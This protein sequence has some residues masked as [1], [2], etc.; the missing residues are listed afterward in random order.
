MLRSFADKETERAWQR[1]RVRK[2]DQG[3]QRAALRK[4][5]ILDAAETLDDLRVPPGNGLEKLKG[6]RARSHSVR[7]NQQ[8]RICFRW[9]DAGPEDVQIVDYH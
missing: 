8:R 6:D 2:L 3:V 7:V 4:L 5:L 1:K 9:T